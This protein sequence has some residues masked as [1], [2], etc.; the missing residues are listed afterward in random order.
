QVKS[1]N[2]N[3]V[4]GVYVN[5]GQAKDAKREENN[6]VE[7]TDQNGNKK[8]YNENTG[9]DGDNNDFEV[10][11]SLK[12]SGE[13]SNKYSD[14]LRWM[15]EGLEGDQ[16]DIFKINNEPQSNVDVKSIRKATKYLVFE[17]GWYSDPGDGDYLFSLQSSSENGID[18]FSIFKE[19][20][21]IKDPQLILGM[22]SPPQ[23][24]SAQA[25]EE[26]GKEIIAN[27]V[28]E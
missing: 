3:I 2:T 6:S 23:A 5:E 20:M 22:N 15:Y 21:H 10:D 12:H 17:E 9:D 25:D 7:D 24:V 14:D 19:T 13:G 4:H 27:D 1:T 16:D 11:A 8:N 26:K 28:N 18:K